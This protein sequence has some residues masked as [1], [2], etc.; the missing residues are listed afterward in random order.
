M[1][2]ADAVNLHDIRALAARRLP[3][4]AFDFVDGGVDDEW[5]LARNEAALRRPLLLP[6]YGIDVELRD[7]SVELFGRRYSA[8][9]GISPM[10]YAGLF[11]PGA[12]LMMAA[13]AAA[14]DVPFIM[15][16]GS[17]NTLEEAARVAP[18]HLWFQIY[19]SRDHA[20]LRDLMRRAAA[21]G[22]EVLVVTVD[23]PVNVRRERNIRNGFK[24]PLRLSTNLVLE[25]LRH[26]G[27]LAG[28]YR[29]GG[30]PMMRNWQPYLPAGAT[31]EDVADLYGSQTPASGQTWDVL[32]MIRQEWPH[33][34]VL[35][36]VLHPGDA[37][38]AVDLGIDALFISN[39]GGRQLDRAPA[40]I[41]VLPLI[42]RE[43]GPGVPLLMDSGLRRGSDLVV[44][45]ALGVRMGFVGRPAMYGAAAGGAAG[46]AKML[47]IL[48]AQT[49][50]VL[51]QIGC[52]RAD[53]LGPECL[54][55]PA[56]PA[57]S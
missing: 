34:L 25:G 23:V 16:S 20:I 45:K 48:K 3:R 9:V 5:G 43:V 1:R 24:R 39:H 37:R 53:A 41:E 13:A 29:S 57:A 14:A 15:S 4:I 44:A 7:Q 32:Q 46:V 31:S 22:I 6:R 11:R 12:D 40:P 17:N 49:D 38:R 36:G 18:G 30:L 8:P 28:Y 55:E 47:A 50:S 26:P 27:W 54:F 56:P 35:K 33:R 10:G 19:G 52:P 2:I 21:A 51:G 42:R